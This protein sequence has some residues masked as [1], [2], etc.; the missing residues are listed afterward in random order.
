MD[1]V[2]KLNKYDETRLAEIR[3]GLEAFYLN[4][5]K[6]ILIIILSTVFD[7]T[8][9]TLLF[10]IFNL[11]IRCVSFGFHANTSFQC[12]I[13]STL[14][15]ILIPL[16]AD[17]FLLHVVTKCIIYFCLAIGFWILA[18]KDTEKKPIVNNKKRFWLKIVSVLIVIIYF[19]LTLFIRNNLVINLITL[20][21]ATQFIMVSPIPFKLFK[22][23][24]NFK[25]FK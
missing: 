21:L 17:Y 22:Q 5:T 9:Y 13:I 6:L 20:A 16:L 7:T 1:S 10:F 24:Y 8:K 23:N 25:W 12:L 2:K 15:F 3:Y 4:I 19:C 11:P 18:P 14:A